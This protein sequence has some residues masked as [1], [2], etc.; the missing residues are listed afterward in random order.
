MKTVPLND[1]HNSLN[2]KLI[3]FAGWRLPVD[4][5]SAIREVQAVRTAAGLFD[6]SHMGRLSFEGADTLDALQKL[7]TNDL[8]RMDD[9]RCLYTLMC[10]PAGGVIDDLI[11]S[12]ASADLYPMIVNAANHD[13]DVAWIKDHL[14]ASVKLTDHTPTT[15]MLALQ[16]PRAIEIAVA[17]GATN[18]PE[19]GRFRFAS[20]RIGQTDV[21]LSRTGYTGED[22]FEITC[23]SE[24]A[25]DVWNTI[26]S[27]GTDHG[28]IPCGLAARDLLRIEAALPLYGHEIDMDIN[29]VEAG[30]ARWIKPEKGD[31]IGREPIV[32][33]LEGDISRKLVGIKMTVRAVPRAGDTVTIPPGT[34]PPGTIPPGILPTIP[35]GILPGGALGTGIVT[36]G[37]Y[38][39]TLAAGIAMAYLPPDVAE[40]MDVEIAVHGKAQP[41]K[42]CALPFYTRGRS[43]G[44][45]AQ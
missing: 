37:T 23:P 14:P 20:G 32:K 7:L 2:G 10:N 33:A 22:G 17:A 5:G 9:G 15:A 35:P 18:A 13:K 25:A 41:G 16:G 40:G 29:P 36:S 38:S 45:K 21:T 27:A 1:I 24:S 26:M 31:F 43:S 30:L 8:A 4:Y 28:L 19:I 6:V 39:P 34:M 12:R 11:V 42:V 3:D 44:D